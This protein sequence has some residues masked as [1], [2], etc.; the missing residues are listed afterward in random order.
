MEDNPREKG[1]TVSHRQITELLRRWR[2]G[3]REAE[4]RLFE[5]VQPDILRLARSYMRRE[6]SNHT[7][8]SM[9]LLQEAF[10]KL[11]H[12]RKIEW[13]DRTHFFAFAARAMRRFLIDYARPRDGR[14]KLPLDE[15]GIVARNEDM[16]LAVEVDRL[17]QELE[18]ADPQKCA[19]VELKFF[20]G[21]TDNEAADVLHVPLRTVQRRWRDARK[22]LFDRLE[23]QGW[24]TKKSSTMND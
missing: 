12:A 13:Q 14:V 22:W 20:L 23:K 2:L 15:L 9:D 24:K 6:R 19:V 4:D 8:E 16:E 17:L 1:K 5:I 10:L 7:L 11:N 18:I 21:L 3:E